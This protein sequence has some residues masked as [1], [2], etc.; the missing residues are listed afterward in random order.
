MMWPLLNKVIQEPPEMAP[1]P[2]GPQAKAPWLYIAT[3]PQDLQLLTSAVPWGQPITP[4]RIQWPVWSG[5][6]LANF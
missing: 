3:D 4:T 1:L 6:D 2:L 5:P